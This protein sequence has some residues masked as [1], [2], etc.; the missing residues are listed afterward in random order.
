MPY[1][2]LSSNHGWDDDGFRQLLVHTYMY[3]SIWLE[4][5]ETESIIADE[6][7]AIDKELVDQKKAWH[8]KN[9]KCV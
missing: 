8:C 3:T 9:L 6:M 1:L 4:I 5:E 7:K 2:F